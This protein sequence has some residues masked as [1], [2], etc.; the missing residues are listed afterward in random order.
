MENRTD[1]YPSKT[2][3][4]YTVFLLLVVYTFSFIDRQILGLLGP[5]IIE[6]FEI[7]DTQFGILT[8]FAFAVFYTAFGLLCAR[9]ADSR[10]RKG[11]IAVGLALWSLMTAGSALAQSY[12]HLFLM[13]MGVGVGEA[14]LAPGANSIIADSFPKER[15]ATALSVYSM[16]I[17][18]GSAIAFIIGGKVLEISESLP[19][20]T[21]PMVG[22][23]SGWQ[24]TF[25][26]VGIP[27]LLLTVL[28]L[29]L[30]EPT[31][32]G[33]T[34]DKASL[35]VSEVVAFL[36]TRARAMSGL[37]MGV[38]LNA[39]VGFGTATFLTIFFM[40]KHGMSPADVGITFGVM[41][42]FT[43]SL[44]LLVGGWIA[45]KLVFKGRK[46]AHILA[47][48]V[49]PLGYFIPSVLFPQMS[50]L[51]MAWI[52]LGVAN[53]FINLPSGVAYAGLQII[54]PNQMRGQVIA[55]YV[56]TT[57]IVG[58]GGG[59]FLIGWI[60]DNVFGDP[61]RID[62]AISLVVL[63]TT[64]IGIASFLWC[65]KAFARAVAEEEA[66]IAAGG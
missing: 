53:F 25:L 42:L 23:L 58:Y 3:A 30:K 8:G 65:R 57:S 31:R 56:L 22:A 52:I 32:K 36:K 19:D 16:G 62:D 64:P 60:V 17:P 21:L 12:L 55:L 47:L 7:S 49:A 18:V 40:R 2:Y 27:G 33:L 44:G 43:G 20:I 6:D 4:W 1:D 48:M 5:A 29:L 34:G 11:L 39:C 51:T 46:D 41:S 50:D 15:L 35:P 45:D 66:R 63:I 24:K 54:T 37:C 10:P 26:I 9:I 38:S 28:I 59:P 61:M 13:R 14:T